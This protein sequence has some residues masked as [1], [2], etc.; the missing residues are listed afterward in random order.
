MTDGQVSYSQGNFAHVIRTDAGSP[1][2][3]VVI[4]LLKPQGEPQNQCEEN[5]IVAGP[6]AYH[7]SKTLADRS[8][9]TAT[10]PLFDTD[11][12]HV[13]LQWYGSNTTQIEPTY[14]L[15]TLIVILSGSICRESKKANL[16]RPCPLAARLGLSLNLLT[17]S[18][19]DREILGVIFLFL[20][21]GLSRSIQSGSLDR[22]FLVCVSPA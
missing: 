8:K 20:L 17:V 22:H 19:I 21:K 9:G 11:Q 14:R 1:L 5:Q 2:D 12:T 7:C 6:P 13:S 18:L 3:G 10:V 4:E 15:G 16:K